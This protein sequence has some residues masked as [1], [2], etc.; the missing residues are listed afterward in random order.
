M[1]GASPATAGIIRKW[2]RVMQSH[3]LGADDVVLLGISNAKR[4]SIN[5]V[6]PPLLDSLSAVLC[7]ALCTPGINL[8]DGREGETTRILKAERERIKI[9]WWNKKKKEKRG[10]NNNPLFIAYAPNPNLW[11]PLFY[12][13]VFHPRA[14]FFSFTPGF[15]RRRAGQSVR[16]FI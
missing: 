12:S 2:S 10:N 4:A 14:R 15:K 3:V 6:S 8:S 9:T 1:N 5:C 13:W 11:A 16:K 7:Y